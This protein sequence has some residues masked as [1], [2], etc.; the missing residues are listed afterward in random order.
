[1]EGMNYWE[2]LKECKLYSIQRR[3]ERFKIL[4]MY[5]SMA[6]M[7]PSLGMNMKYCPRKGNMFILPKLTGTVVR[8]KTLKDKSLPYVG[9]KLFNSLPQCLRNMEFSKEGFP[10]FKCVLDMFLQC[11]PDCPCLPGYV[12]HNLDLNTSPSNS[13]I[14]WIR[15]EKLEVWMPDY[16]SSSHPPRDGPIV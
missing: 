9:A 6:G 11:I 3:N 12:S 7:V 1:M 10:V 16:P 5:K 13:I 2:R 14:D 8:I 4:Y 15:N